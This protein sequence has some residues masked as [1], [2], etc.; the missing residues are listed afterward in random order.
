MII[1]D[2]QTR[3]FDFI[4]EGSVHDNCVWLTMDQSKSY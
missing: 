2:D 3:I 4:V 1:C